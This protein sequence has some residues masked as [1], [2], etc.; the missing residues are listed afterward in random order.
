[1]KTTRVLDIVSKPHVVFI[2]F[3]IGYQ[4]L[5][6][7]TKE[8][9]PK[10][11]VFNNSFSTV[12]NNVYITI[13][14]GSRIQKC[15]TLQSFFVQHN[16][17]WLVFALSIFSTFGCQQRWDMGNFLLTHPRDVVD[18]TIIPWARVALHLGQ[19]H[20][21]DWSYNLIETSIQ[22]KYLHFKF[23]ENRNSCAHLQIFC[24]VVPREG[25]EHCRSYGFHRWTFASERE[26]KKRHFKSS[27]WE[28]CSIG[29][30]LT[31]YC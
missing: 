7:K 29:F 17:L 11:S 3:L 15:T 20:V 9:K 22:C 10:N 2:W 4:D 26:T 23:S 14:K 30:E 31:S 19:V 1:M 13:S 24:C 18:L 16:T 6:I 5:R 8:I 25:N 21:Y 27:F 12:Y 28:I